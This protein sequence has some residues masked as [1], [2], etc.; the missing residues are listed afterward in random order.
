VSTR[1]QQIAAIT[2]ATAKGSQIR[3]MR[4]AAKGR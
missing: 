3:Q 4:R 1:S 2:I